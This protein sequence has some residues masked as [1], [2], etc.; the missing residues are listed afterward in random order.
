MEMK[1]WKKDYVM[2]INQALRWIWC[3]NLKNSKYF[4][5]EVFCGKFPNKLFWP[6]GA[7]FWKKKSEKTLRS[8][9]NPGFAVNLMHKLKIFYIFSRRS[10]LLREAPKYAVLTTRGKILKKKLCSGMRIY[11]RK[12]NWKW[13][14]KMMMNEWGNFLSSVKSY[15]T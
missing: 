2:A 11:T 8:D 6:L 12:S 1:I 3:T 13:Q 15:S 5:G 10:R 7:K 9:L 14:E 4:Q